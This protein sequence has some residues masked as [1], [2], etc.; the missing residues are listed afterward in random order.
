[1]ALAEKFMEAEPTTYGPPCGV[2]VL[3]KSLTDEERDSFLAIMAVPA[4]QKGRI[5][6]RK[7]HSILR[8]EGYDTSFSSVTLHR[9]RSCRC[10]I[11]KTAQD[12]E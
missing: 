9:R 3:L 10:Y 6:N 1:M 11:G 5:S 7:I 12:S 4:G 2:A 8:S